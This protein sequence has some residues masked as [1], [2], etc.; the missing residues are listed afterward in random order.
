MMTF[1]RNMKIRGKLF[2]G[3]FLVLAITVFIAVFGITNINTNFALLQDYPSARYDTLNYLATEIT[4]LRRLVT[5]MAFRL[6]DESTLNELRAEAL[7]GR[8][9]MDRLVNTN[10]ASLNSDILIDPAR[11]PGG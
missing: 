8:T 6:G 11:R 3:F 9:N 4:D 10:V 5:A 1:V 2:F 7:R